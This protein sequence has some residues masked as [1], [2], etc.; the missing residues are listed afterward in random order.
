MDKEGQFFSNWNG[1]LASSYGCFVS[2]CQISP[3]FHFNTLEKLAVHAGKISSGSDSSIIVLIYVLHLPLA[4]CLAQLDISVAALFCR[5]SFDFTQ[6]V[7]HCMPPHN[8]HPLM[9][10]I[11]RMTCERESLLW[12]II[13]NGWSFG[14]VLRCVYLVKEL[15]F[16][17]FSWNA[18]AKWK[19]VV[20]SVPWHIGRKDFM[21]VSHSWC[22]FSIHFF[23]LRS[24]SFMHMYM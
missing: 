20:G 7:L 23:N 1:N 4:M 9:L 11:L 13:T 18:H 24:M 14:H 2:S 3:I 8:L 10:V 17:C 5:C 16:V 22:E 6:L 19:A 15:M 12:G 21:T